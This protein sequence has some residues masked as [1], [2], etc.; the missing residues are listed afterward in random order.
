MLCIY[1][2]CNYEYLE[3]LQGT[4]APH[5]Q[6]ILKDA[7]SPT[8][9][10]A[11]KRKK[12]STKSISLNNDTLSNING[13]EST[14]GNKPMYGC[15]PGFE[16]VSEYLCLH[17]S[18]NSTGHTNKYTFAQSKFYCENKGN[19]AKVLSISN[20]ADALAL[21]K[22]ISNHFFSIFNQ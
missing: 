5:L 14:I 21:W 3:T 1:S 9:E 6:T 8:N 19:G 16:K 13:K 18:Q 7:I 15:P 22:W 11:E 12:R 10:S 4:V 2:K 17:L 20:S